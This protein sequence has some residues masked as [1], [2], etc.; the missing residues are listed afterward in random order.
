MSVGVATA[1]HNGTSVAEI[2]ASADIALYRAKNL[3]RNRVVLS[4][5]HPSDAHLSVVTRIA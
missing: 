1:P 3:G 5:E 4:V 2:F